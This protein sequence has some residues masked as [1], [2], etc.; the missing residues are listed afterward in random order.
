MGPERRVTRSQVH[1]PL[2]E[3]LLQENGMAGAAWCD[4]FVFGFR[5]IGE[6]GEPGDYP[7]SSET[8]DLLSGEGIFAA[9]PTRFVSAKRGLGPSTEQLCQAAL[10]Q[11]E[12]NWL[13]GP[14]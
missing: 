6:I 13:H 7:L 1:A 9:A 8:S 5:T 11:V 10:S 14:D 4:Q 12:K 3:E 2:V